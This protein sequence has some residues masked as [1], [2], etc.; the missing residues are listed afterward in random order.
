M[1]TC[2]VR[3]PFR[4]AEVRDARDVRHVVRREQ[5][6]RGDDDAR[7][8]PQAV[9]R[10]DAPAT[11]PLVED[12]G[13]HARTEDDVG[14]QREAVRDVVQVALELRLADEVLG[15]VSRLERL[16]RERVRI[17]PA[18]GVE[19]RARVAIPLPGPADAPARFED[20]RV[21]ADLPEAVELVEAGDPGADDQGVD[22]LDRG[23]GHG[24][25]LM[26][27][28]LVGSIAGTA[29][30][31]GT[32]PAGRPAPERPRQDCAVILEMAAVS[33]MRGSSDSPGGSLTSSRLI[34]RT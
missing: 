10:L 13:A 21:E 29:R 6:G 8:D 30:K 31:E 12:G 7:A 28:R 14:T 26:A 32:E 15:P 18:L 27:W 25:L 9:L 19:P 24:S 16:A 2:L 20:P 11:R 5:P 4:A 3:A 1:S 33:K 22:S 17:A 34:E 23:I